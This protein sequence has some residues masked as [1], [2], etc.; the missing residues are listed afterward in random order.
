MDQGEYVVVVDDDPD[1]L[2][3]ANVALQQ[4]GCVLPVRL[5]SSGRELMH[6]LTAAQPDTG[7]PTPP[8]RCIFLDLR[9]P[10]IS[11]QHVIEKLR[12]HPHLAD[13]P[14]IAMS[15]TMDN[16]EGPGALSAGASAYISKNLPS[17]DFRRAVQKA[18]LQCLEPGR[19]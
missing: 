19:G 17:D 4:C 9:M 3:L 5:V 18:L 8:P 14:V 6:I 10:G 13:V 16:S 11:G 1:D 7:T 15:G 12:M 2:L